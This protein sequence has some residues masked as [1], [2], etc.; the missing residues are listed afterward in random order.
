MLKYPPRAAGARGFLVWMM[1]EEYRQE[2]AR[3]GKKNTKR[4]KKG[5]V[6]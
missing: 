1:L 4:K 2:K 3:K 5:R 6:G